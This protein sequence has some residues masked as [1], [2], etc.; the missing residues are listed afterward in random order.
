DVDA[1]R[2]T[3]RARGKAGLFYGAQT[4]AKLAGA[5]SIDGAP[6][7]A[8]TRAVPCVH[9]DDSPRFAF[10]GMHLDVARHFFDKTVVERYVDLLAFYKL[11]VF[12][13]HLTD[14]QGFR[15]R[16][17]S[18]PELATEPAFSQDEVREIVSY[19]RD[20]FVTVIPEIEMPGHARAILA[21]HPELSCNGAPLPLPTTWGVF[22]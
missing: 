4:L 17:P 5:R 18:H 3:I 2:A 11:N 16:L 6:R 9:I 20:R 19:A 21:S 10:R 12:H 13:W 14:D 22:E 8:P 1:S 15:L 7:A